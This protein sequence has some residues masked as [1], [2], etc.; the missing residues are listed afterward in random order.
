[1]SEK[2]INNASRTHA[3]GMTYAYGDINI[4]GFSDHAHARERKRRP[5]S[6]A[7]ITIWRERIF[8]ELGEDPVKVAV[9]E[10]IKD[11]GQEKDFTLWAWYANRI[12][13]N[14]FL[15]LYFEQKSIMRTS[16]LRNPAAA[17]HMRLKRFYAA[18]TGKE[19]AK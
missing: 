15:E 4:T 12:G 17:F 2:V 5:F 18:M 3:R 16:D 7:E 14:N 6:D 19:V 8:T 1:M 9:S 11:F 10:A 13:V